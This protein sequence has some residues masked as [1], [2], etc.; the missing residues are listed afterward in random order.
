M[1]SKDVIVQSPTGTGKTLAF[2]V[3]MV[4]FLYSRA[5]NLST[6]KVYGLVLAPTRELALQLQ[7]VIKMFETEIV[8]ECFIG[9]YDL[10][11]DVETLKRNINIVI[12]TPGRLYE[13]I[14][15][16]K[17]KFTS[18]E[19]LILDEGDK[20][21]G[22]GFEGV[23]TRILSCIPRQRR[24]GLFTATLDDSIKKL[25]KLSLRNP[26]TIQID[27]ESMIPQNLTI[28]Y[29]LTKPF[30]KL[31]YLMHLM[32]N[33]TCL[34]FFSTC[35]Q[36][37][38]FYGLT[39]AFGCKSVMKI[40]GRMSQEE[41]KG[42]YEAFTDKGGVLFCTDLASRGIDFKMV[43][44]VIHFDVPT[45]PMTFIHR[46]GRTARNGASGGAILF[47]MKNEECYIDYLSIKGIGVVKAKDVELKELK[48]DEIKPLFNDELR[49]ASLLAYISYIRAYKEHRL[50]YIM[51]LKDLDF[52]SVTA[53]HFL[54]KIPQMSELRNVTF[55]RFVRPERSIKEKTKKSKRAR[56]I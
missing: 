38:Y 53:L 3:P 2:L 48:Y 54:E 8:S 36:V 45:D 6:K 18:L 12:G 41:R 31:S 28:E 34:V 24:T 9:G 42:I 27:E 15:C 23:I 32:N 17:S 52:D 11:K 25:S 33:G 51:S 29:I 47:V 7:E 21:L 14:R 44:T 43:G 10:E 56:A 30:N 16:H 19:F 39:I 46:S 26:I 40:H 4:N 37:D 13:L 1:K 35:A 49:K 55:K 20:L 5:S 22:Y 50:S